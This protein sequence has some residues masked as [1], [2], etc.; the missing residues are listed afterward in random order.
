M[1]DKDE[2]TPT[3]PTHN[4]IAKKKEGRG[5]TT[6]GVAWDRGNGRFTLKFNSF[7]DM[8]MLNREDVT[9]AIGPREWQGHAKDRRTMAEKRRA[10]LDAMVPKDDEDLDDGEIPF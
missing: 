2:H 4:I 3:K 6:V 10:E 5:F 1:T 9:V 8:R 7:I